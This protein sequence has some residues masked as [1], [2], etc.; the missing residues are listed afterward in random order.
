MLE[1]IVLVELDSHV[2]S[3]FP[4][5]IQDHIADLYCTEDLSLR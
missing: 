1:A 2:S 4:R 3:F 5:D